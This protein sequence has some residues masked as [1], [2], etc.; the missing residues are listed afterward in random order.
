MSLA[1]CPSSASHT[2]GGPEPGLDASSTVKGAGEDLLCG[3]I[4]GEHCPP[5]SPS[6]GDFI[7]SPSLSSMR[8]NG[9]LQC[10]SESWLG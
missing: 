8:L 1:K 6:S 9:E 5:S 10:F 4:P 3:S 2:M 7:R